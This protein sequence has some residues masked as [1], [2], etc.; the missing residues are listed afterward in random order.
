MVPV[1]RSFADATAA[2]ERRGRSAGT[3][4]AAEGVPMADGVGDWATQLRDHAA[5]C[6][7]AAPLPDRDAL[8]AAQEW[9]CRIVGGALLTWLRQHGPRF[10]QE[11]AVVCELLGLDRD[12]AVVFTSDVPGLVAA[13]EVVGPDHERVVY[14]LDDEFAAAPARAADPGYKH[15]VHFWSFFRPEVEAGFAAEAR[16][17]HPIPADCSYWQHSEGTM[18]A[19]TAGRGADHLWRWDG[20]TPE[21]LEEAM[22]RWVA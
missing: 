13:R 6:R 11:R 8:T 7:A 10:L 1:L 21:L 9:R 3:A 20:H 18:W 14:L 17:R 22:S 2:G 12:P 5:A 19:V 4:R 16:A 15:H